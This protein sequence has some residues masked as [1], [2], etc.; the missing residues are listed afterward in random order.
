MAAKMTCPGGTSWGGVRGGGLSPTSQAGRR[1]AG[2]FL[3]PASGLASACR[4]QRYPSP[5]FSTETE[6][7]HPLTIRGVP[8]ALT[9]WV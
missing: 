5:G 3:V 9:P 1:W 8:V 7:E 4:M 6:G 2:G